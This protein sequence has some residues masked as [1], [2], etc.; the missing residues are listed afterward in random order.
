MSA[1][2]LPYPDD[3]LDVGPAGDFSEFSAEGQAAIAAALERVRDGTAQ[4]VPHDDVLAHLE[5]ERLVALV[6]LKTG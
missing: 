2:H 4:A 5:R 6:A 3:D 1:A